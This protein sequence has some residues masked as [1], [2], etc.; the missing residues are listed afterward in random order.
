MPVAGERSARLT[1][2]RVS[3]T[4][5]YACM[6]LLEDSM[7]WRSQSTASLL[8]SWDREIGMGKVGGISPQ[9]NSSHGRVAA[10]VPTSLPET[11]DTLF[12]R[13]CSL[14]PLTPWSGARDECL[15]RGSQL[16]C[17][18]AACAEPLVHSTAH[19]AV[20]TSFEHATRHE[21]WLW[22]YFTH[23]AIATKFRCYSTWQ[24][25]PKYLLKIVIRIGWCSHSRLTKKQIFFLFEN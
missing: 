3:L 4:R 9:F 7:T 16:A 25:Q 12:Q 10:A 6:F 5:M 24:L 17:P 23:T 21:H 2:A 22:T 15:A 1:P 13:R 8:P 18:C 19:G 11:G 20:G 14:A